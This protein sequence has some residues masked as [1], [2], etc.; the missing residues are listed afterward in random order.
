MKKFLVSLLFGLIGIT[1]LYA[2]YYEP[3]TNTNF[4]IGFGVSYN[5][6]LPSDIPQQEWEEG[7]GFNMSCMFG[8]HLYID[9]D[10]K[11]RTYANRFGSS[12][13]ND[14]YSVNGSAGVILP[15]SSKFLITPIIG[16]AYYNVGY[17][18][19]NNWYY[20]PTSNYRYELYNEY[21]SLYSKTYLNYGIKFDYIIFN[22]NYCN[23]GLTTKITKYNVM[24][25]VNLYLRTIN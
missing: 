7:L 16:V 9:F 25:G 19:G 21:V 13:W 3:E 4:G 5:Y 22:E 14:Y 17:T 1:H 10:Y 2:Q 18:D 15:I 23:F 11:G 24:F 6:N 8:R 20:R 12:I